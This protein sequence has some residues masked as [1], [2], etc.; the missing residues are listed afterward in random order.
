MTIVQ[1]IQIQPNKFVK[2]FC[3]INEDNLEVSLFIVCNSDY[4]V[5]HNVFQILH[6]LSKVFG[7]LCHGI[8]CSVPQGKK[9]C[10]TL[11]DMKNG[12]RYWLDCTI[13][14]PSRFFLFPSFTFLKRQ[15][16][17][18]Y[19][20]YSLIMVLFESWTIQLT[21]HAIHFLTGLLNSQSFTWF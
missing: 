18:N 5:R 2:L 8:S 7:F 16:K 3:K 6:E 12:D 17:E 20:S 14:R 1:I 4:S 19:R 13:F 10:F 11:Q 9:K 21:R 15:Q